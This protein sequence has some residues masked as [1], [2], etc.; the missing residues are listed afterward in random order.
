LR[1]FELPLPPIITQGRI[2]QKLDRIIDKIELMKRSVLK[3]QNQMEMDLY[4]LYNKI[5]AERFST[6][7]G[8]KGDRKSWETKRLEDICVSISSGFAEGNKNVEDGIIHLRM[9]NIGINFEIN[10]DLVRRVKV[11]G[12]KL[13]KYKL[14]YGDILFNNTNSVALV[15][16]SAIFTK[17]E[18]CLYSNHLT[19]L[20]PK[21]K[22]VLSEWILFYLRARWL[23]GDFRRLS[24]KWINQAA[25]HK[26][27]IKDLEIPMPPLDV[28]FEIVKDLQKTSFLISK[29]SDNRKTIIIRNR[30]TETELELLSNRILDYAFTGRLVDQ[31]S[32]PRTN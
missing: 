2:V 16:K 30:Q 22:E 15:G 21:K 20:R 14:E 26:E 19:R 7:I 13:A 23:K 32:K 6:L 17:P 10:L 5:L 11:W 28:Q 12:V 4:I 8:L 18:I 27:K 31:D 1:A 9:N 25:V 29:T 3:L 24:N